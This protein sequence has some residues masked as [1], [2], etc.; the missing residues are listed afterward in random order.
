MR[1]RFVLATVLSSLVLL[2]LACVVLE[3][4]RITMHHDAEAD[5]LSFLIEYD[6]IFDSDE[7]VSED[8]LSTLRRY[9]AQRNV[10]F[11]D[12]FGTVEFEN[13]REI[14]RRDPMRPSMKKCLDTF[15][16]ST[17]VKVLGRYRDPRGR[18]GVAQLVVIDHVSQVLD[19][20]NDGICESLLDAAESSE[21]TKE[22]RRRSM[23]RILD[24]ARAKHRW[25]QLDGHSLVVN[26]PVHLEEFGAQRLEFVGDLF[27]EFANMVNAPSGKRE[28]LGPETLIGLLGS[29]P[30][31]IVQANDSITFRLGVV[32]KPVTLRIK[33]RE[34]YRDHLEQ[35]LQR[36]IPTDLDRELAATGFGVG[37]GKASGLPA[38]A[39]PEDRVRAALG[40]HA[41]GTS[42]ERGAAQ[43][44][45]EAFGKRWNE[46]EGYPAAPADAGTEAGTESTWRAQWTAWFEAVSG[47]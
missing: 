43:R 47:T 12:W 19:L 18:V 28:E 10:M 22:S 35:E 42:E 34:G 44:W 11:L 1:T 31:S 40:A 45:L 7:E 24:A 6:G 14:S 25:I 8:S 21:L 32:E 3:G 2:P 20:L 23:R 15:L 13:L 16:A 4:Q 27:R 41:R 17:K 33:M 39:P 9:V 29:A 37:D 46:A 5:R 30:L 26:V 38:W 36:L